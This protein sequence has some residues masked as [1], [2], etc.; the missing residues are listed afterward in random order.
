MWLRLRSGESS[1]LV[2]KPAVL[3]REQEGGRL[4]C[5]RWAADAPPPQCASGTGGSRSVVAANHGC[6]HSGLRRHRYSEAVSC[7]DCQSVTLVFRIN[8]PYD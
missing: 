7:R 2:L 1:P 6:H 8:G 4:F 5:L 3:L